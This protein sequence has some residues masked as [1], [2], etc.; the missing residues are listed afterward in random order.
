MKTHHAR[1]LQGFS[2][3]RGGGA[4]IRALIVAL[5]VLLPALLAPLVAAAQEPDAAERLAERYAPVMYLKDQLAPC[6]TDGEPFLPAPIEVTFDE[7]VIFRSEPGAPG[8]APT[9]DGLFVAQPDHYIDLPG[10][11]RSPG[12]IYETDFKD[13]MGDQRPVV[14]AHIA[15]EEGQ[16]GLALQYW[17]FFWFNDYNNVHEGDWEGIQLRFEASTLEEA[18]TQ[19][20]TEIAFAQ[21]EGGETSAWT[22]PKLE[23]EG[24][25]P[26]V[27]TSRGSHASYYGPAVWLGWGRDGSGLGCDITTGPSVRID[28]EVRLVPT[29]PAGPDDP[30]AWL[31]FTGRW[32]ERGESFFNGPTGPPDKLRWTAPLTWQD[33]LRPSSVPLRAGPA[34]GPAATGVYCDLIADAS[35]LYIIS[36]PYPWIVVAVLAVAAVLILITATRAWP[37]L[38]EA[39]RL[40]RRHPGAFIAIAAILMPITIIVTAALYAASGDAAVAAVLP[41]DE[42]H[43]ELATLVQTAIGAQQ[44]LLTLLVGPALIWMARELEAG[45][46]PAP[47]D[48]LRTAL[49]VSPRM[50][51]TQLMVFLAIVLLLITIIGIPVAIY[52]GVRWIFASQA[53]ILDGTSGREALRR[54]A[55]ATTGRWWRTALSLP[56]F[57][58]AG[59]ALAPVIGILLMVVLDLQLD[60]ANGVG[61]LVYLLTQPLAFIGLTVMYLWG[62]KALRE[63]QAAG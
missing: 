35:G 59:A 29:E 42:D 6:D 39:W 24:D 44:L 57:A 51:L 23:R 9:L 7:R 13:V 4:A 53:V 46:R 26:V 37:A 36:Q 32:G 43:P 56:T 11:P 5:I 18:L 55:E 47:M 30:A 50:A 2:V 15:T 1:E 12:C 48:A 28:P 58:F 60:L 10:H 16:P 63:R 33:S 34:L 14:Y 25:R 20:P 22:S 62:A 19:E 54:S 21:H 40:Y 61:S 45:R 17:F 27:Y 52:F 41:L 38:T 31:A 3:R 49:R 8:E